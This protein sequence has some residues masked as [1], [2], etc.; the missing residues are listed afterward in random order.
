MDYG[1]GAYAIMDDNVTIK[2]LE[3]EADFHSALES[4][5]LGYWHWDAST[6]VLR[7]DSRMHSIYGT[8]PA[9]FGNT[10][11]SFEALLIPEDRERIAQA[12][13]HSI[14][15]GAPFKHAFRL[16]NGRMVIGFGNARYNMEG[17]MTK[18]VGVNMLV[19][20]DKDSEPLCSHFCPLAH[21][22]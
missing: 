16:L 6:D 22:A 15:T 11:A 2:L 14:D 5:G 12:V 3:A 4:A 18:L 7:W 17:V 19:R 9:T 10:Y 8:T 13:K 21:A 20:K 1:K